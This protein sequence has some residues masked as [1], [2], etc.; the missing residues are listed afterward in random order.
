MNIIATDY[1]VDKGDIE[2]SLAAIAEAGYRHVHWV[3]HWNDDYF[4]TPSEIRHI[5]GW[6]SR[7]GLAMPNLHS[8]HGIEKQWGN[9]D[10]YRRQA[11]V[12]LVGNRVRMTAELGGD[13]V[14]LHPFYTR[15]PEG[16]LDEAATGLNLAAMRRSLDELRPLCLEGGV[17]LALENL[18]DGLQVFEL[19][20]RLLG[21]YPADFLGLCFDSG[22]GNMTP[23]SLDL[24]DQ[25]KDRLICMHLHDNLGK[26]DQ[27]L[28]PYSGTVDWT[29]MMRLIGGSA[30]QDHVVLEVSRHSYKDMTDAQFLS[31]AREIGEKL[32]SLQKS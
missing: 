15:Q 25:W 17:R 4:Y 9:P 23:G 27:H 31:K 2:P 16:L 18:P 8:S 28:L 24:L 5:R 22:H 11:G 20:T 32:L 19:V 12:E 7:Y 29:G 6:F 3:Q 30:Y 13:V 26:A 14:V 10:E 1:L 21:E